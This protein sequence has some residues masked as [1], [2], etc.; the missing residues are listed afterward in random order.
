MAARHADVWNVPE[1]A[2][3][4]APAIIASSLITRPSGARKLYLPAS[5][6][7]KARVVTRLKGHADIKPCERVFHDKFGYGLI[8][9]VD[10]DKPEIIFETA[11]KK[12]VVG[13]LLVR[14]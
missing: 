10:G 3:H 5:Y 14:A 11:G 6:R 7:R 4:S 1:A 12:N 8:K 13:S 9:S 2:A